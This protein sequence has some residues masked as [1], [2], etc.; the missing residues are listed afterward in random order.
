MRPHLIIWIIAVFITSGTSAKQRTELLDTTMLRYSLSELLS[1]DHFGRPNYS[2]LKSL[3]SSHLLRRP[4]YSH[5]GSRQSLS[6]VGAGVSVF[7]SNCRHVLR[8]TSVPRGICYGNLCYPE[9]F[10]QNTVV[11][12]LCS[13]MRIAHLNTR[14]INNK[15]ALI[16]DTILDR[17]IDIL[18]LSETW[19]KENDLS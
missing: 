1:L 5:R 8:R 4:C 13:N 6:V 14:S 12:V 7:W 2:V 17:K 18:C 9:T 15:T 19:H 16:T 11:N 10:S 3:R